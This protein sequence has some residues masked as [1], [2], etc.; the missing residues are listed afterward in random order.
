MSQD[1]NSK[2]RNSG[3]KPRQGGNNSNN[4]N[5][6][7]N[8]NRN[9]NRNRQGQGQGGGNRQGGS[10]GGQRR[11]GRQSGGGPRKRTPKP[12]PLTF[13]EK[14]LKVFGLYKA[15]TRPPRR[16][17]AAKKAAEGNKKPAKSNTRNA[18]SQSTADQ[19][20][21]ATG[22]GAG[23]AG[24]DFPVE[25]PRLYLGNL[26]YDASEQD[27]EDLFKGIGSVRSIEIIYNR[28]THRSKGYGFIEML[29][30]EEA[31]RAVEVLHDKAFMGRNLVVNGAS[32]KP[33]ED[34]PPR[35]SKPREKTPRERKPARERGERSGKGG[36]NQAR[37]LLGNI[38]P[39]TDESSLED[40]F[41][42]I[43]NVRRVE[44]V[45][46]KQTHKPEG[47]GYVEMQKAEDAQRAIE[48]L[49]DQPFMGSKLAVTS[50][51]EKAEEPKIPE[52]DTAEI[53]V[54]DTPAPAAE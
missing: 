53:K 44:L 45:Y 43:G 12:L 11:Q 29:S 26:S 37:L 42:G 49:H 18:R 50:A 10:Q 7:R 28:H 31:K 33:K 17:P 38:S 1:T 52:A 47:T 13:W 41:K 30:V 34:R 25:T 36:N 5:R 8:R 3:G 19:P 48:I 22:R 4:R 27:L 2:P 24:R 23:A 54:E 21:K 39:N 46:N 35:D 32:A 40:H 14:I 9:K 16:K 15:P 20:I 51:N 6:N